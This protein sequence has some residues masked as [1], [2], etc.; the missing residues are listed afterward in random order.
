MKGCCWTVKIYEEREKIIL[1]DI[2]DFELA[3]IFE[4]GQCFRWNREEDG[5]YIGVVKGKVIHVEKHE[6]T[7]FLNNTTSQDFKGIWHDYFDLARDYG[8][9]KETLGKKDPIMEKATAFGQGIRIL[10][11]EPWEALIS[12]IVSANRGISIIKKSIELLCEKYGEPIGEYRGK[13]YYAFPTPASLLNQ[14]VEEINQCKMGYRSRYILDA[15]VIAAEE[16][17]DIEQLRNLNTSDARTQLLRFT[18]IGPKVADCI[19]LFGYQK[20]DAFPVDVWVKRVMEY[21][22]CPNA[23]NLKEIQQ[24]SQKRFGQL[25]GFAQQYLFYYARSLGIGR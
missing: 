4:C 1:E 6:N 25:A 14:R 12:F 9:I 2:K 13:L 17:I 23:K 3:D 10:R 22:Y 15:A 19:L 18:G 7:V 8:K 21:F 24:D 20:Y 5:S 11:Q 16:Q